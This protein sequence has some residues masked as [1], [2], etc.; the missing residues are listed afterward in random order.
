MRR[1]QIIPY[2]WTCIGKCLP[3]QV[4]LFSDTSRPAM[5]PHV[6]KS[7]DNLEYILTLHVHP[8]DIVKTYLNTLKQPLTNYFHWYFTHINN[9]SLNGR[10]E[11]QQKFG[12]TSNLNHT[13][14][15]DSI[16][17]AALNIIADNCIQPIILK[18]GIFFSSKNT[19]VEIPQM[20]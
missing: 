17:K 1:P 20:T 14:L 5:Q 3:H 12:Q 8:N 2:G 15:L 11:K 4:T 19:F 10:H 13:M 9:H 18:T 16:L 7:Y 6:Q